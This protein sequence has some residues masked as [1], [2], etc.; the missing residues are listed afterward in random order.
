MTVL[1]AET[2]TFQEHRDELLGSAEG[3]FVLVKGEQVVGVYDSKRDAITEGYRRFGNT[4]F[5]VKQVL[6]VETP[7]NFVSQLLGI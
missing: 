6:K 3:K 5:L 2:A 7:Q 1:D 4:P